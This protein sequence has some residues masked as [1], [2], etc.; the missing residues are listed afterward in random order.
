M[1]KTTAPETGTL[2][3]VLR[4]FLHL[5]GG[6]SAAG[7]L[8]FVATLYSAR[9]L[10]SAEFGTVVLVHAYASLWRGLVNIKPFEAIVRYGVPLLEEKDRHGL[11]RLLRVMLLIDF[12]SA[13]A[14]T[15]LG[16]AAAYLA[17][18]IFSWPEGTARIA[19]W[20]CLV[21][22]ASGTATANGILRIY[23]RFDA[24]GRVHIT[25]AIVRLGGVI[26]V[27]AFFGATIPMI[28]GVWAASLGTQYLTMQWLGW[29]VIRTQL[30]REAL[31]GPFEFQR[32]SAEHPGIW[33]F[34]NIVYWQSSLDLVPKQVGTLF[35]GWLLGTEG[36]ALYRI[37]RE[38]AK[39]VSK[40]ALFVRQAVY[41][42]LARLRHRND[43]E[44]NRV[45][46]HLIAIMAVPGAVL[47]GLSIWLGE[48]LLGLAVGQSYV[49]AGV[50]M[51]WFIAA[52]VLDL[53]GAP[54]RPA[55]YTLNRAGAVFRL[56]CAASIAYIALFVTLSQVLGLI[57]P[58]VATLAMQSLSLAGMTI[59]VRRP[60]TGLEK[61]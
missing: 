37:A 9:V 3:R 59:I 19:V 2:G 36:A 41:P 20:Y 54:L 25:A 14:G 28:A 60:T 32:V 50:L 17:A 44:F 39:M 15:G 34:L 12:T 7:I 26:G 27:T 55:A 43:R 61:A 22:L 8:A 18:H 31:L 46:Y 47:T 33:R 24:I 30:P 51:S 42:H 1:S 35:A 40:P 56:Q 48:R 13:I 49:A 6:R 4:N 29:R 5:L 10:G 57:G 23:D 21:L 45:L 38:F 53:V 16:M 52:A 58:G 11:G